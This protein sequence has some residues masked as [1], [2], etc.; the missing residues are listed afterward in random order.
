MS[1]AIKAGLSVSRVEIDRDGKIVIVCSAEAAAIEEENP[2]T[3][4]SVFEGLGD[5]NGNAPAYEEEAAEALGVSR[6]WL[7]DSLP[8]IE[9]PIVGQFD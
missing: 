7:Q 5:G 4:W 3:L 8:T 1:G 2:V 6:R 9:W